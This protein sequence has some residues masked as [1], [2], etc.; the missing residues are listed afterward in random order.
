MNRFDKKM[1]GAANATNLMWPKIM[2]KLEW[3]KNEA[4]D[5]ICHWSN[6]LQ[7]EIDHNH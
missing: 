3:N 5:Y 4:D 1:A 7:F 6:N 2:K